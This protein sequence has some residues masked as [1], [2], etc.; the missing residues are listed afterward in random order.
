MTTLE[1]ARRATQPL[2]R[3]TPPTQAVWMPCLRCDRM[4]EHPTITRECRNC[5]RAGRRHYG[6]TH[7]AGEV[8]GA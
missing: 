4:F 6:N 5:A 1:T 8:S 3:H 2:N 7:P